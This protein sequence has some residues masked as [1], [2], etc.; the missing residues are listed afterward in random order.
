MARLSFSK[1]SLS[2]ES[3]QLKRYRQFLPSLDLKRKQLTA[4]RA[5]AFAYL[6]LTERELQ[7][8]HD[9]IG[10]LLPMLADEHIDLNGLVKIARLEIGEENVVGVHMPV[11]STLE[12]QV[13]P[14][15]FMSKPHWVDQLVEHMSEILALNIQQQIAV[16]RMEIL[17][18]AVKKITQRVNLFDKVLIPR[19][20]ENI[21]QIR[22]FL[23]DAEKAAVIN[24]KLTKQ[25]RL[26]KGL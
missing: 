12:I 1:A 11:L 7:Q 16:Q 15:S 2:K 8:R 20:R 4:Q 24:A 10:E 6:K 22:I 14:Y 19:T 26:K 9:I 3:A 21:R 17:E 23:S 5:K 18:K 25:K 13:L